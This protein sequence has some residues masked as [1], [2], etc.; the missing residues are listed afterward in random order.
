M[1]ERRPRSS[2]HPPPLLLLQR[3][4]GKRAA[5]LPA[6]GHRCARRGLSRFRSGPRAALPAAGV[7]TPG[8]H[9]AQAA[10]LRRTLPRVPVSPFCSFPG[11]PGGERLG[12][13][14]VRGEQRLVPRTLQLQPGSW[15]QAGRRGPRG[16]RARPCPRLPK[17]A[18][19]LF[20]GGGSAPRS[21]RSPGPDSVSS[22]GQ[23]V[24][25]TFSG[26]SAA[27]GNPAFCIA[28]R[29]CRDLPSNM[30]PA[31]KI[32]S[33]LKYRG[34]GLG[35]ERWAGGS[36]SSYS[37]FPR[38]KLPHRSRDK[39]NRKFAA[40]YPLAELYFEN[41]NSSVEIQGCERNGCTCCIQNM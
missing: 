28:G 24:G 12:R 13:C 40:R 11:R 15:P 19:L 14:R 36:N 18:S 20:R 39:E 25:G 4:P 1:H 2:C 23:V 21:G 16:P 7:F 38:Q 34:W 17:L 27:P 29:D 3:R 6:W 30:V 33:E 32:E 37:H 26:V 8:C 31:G 35:V 41:Q 22:V 5:T 9:R 10:L